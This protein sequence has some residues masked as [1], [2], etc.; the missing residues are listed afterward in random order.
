MHAASATMA[1]PVGVMSFD[2]K[3]RRYTV[4]LDDSGEKIVVKPPNLQ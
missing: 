2:A 3:S 4:K 1:R